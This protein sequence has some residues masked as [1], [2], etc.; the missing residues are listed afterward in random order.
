VTSHWPIFSNIRVRFSL[1]YIYLL[2]SCLTFVTVCP[3]IFSTDRCMLRRTNTR[4]WT[5]TLSLTNNINF[6]GIKETKL[7]YMYTFFLS[8]REAIYLNVVSHYR[9][10]FEI[11]MSNK[12]KCIHVILVVYF[13]NAYK[14]LC[15]HTNC[16]VI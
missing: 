2:A 4:F 8:L 15:M 3:M 10:H 5:W 6:A 7:I 1:D 14:C 9:P 16:I 12:N 13:I 11:L